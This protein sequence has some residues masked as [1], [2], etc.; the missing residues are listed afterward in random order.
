MRISDWSS[1]VCSSDLGHAALHLGAAGGQRQRKNVA[2]RLARQSAQAVAKGGGQGRRERRVV[3]R[4]QFLG[5]FRRA[6]P[7]HRIGVRRLARKS[8]VTGKRVSE[9]G[10]LGGSRFVQKTK[11]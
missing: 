4:G 10:D 9:R 6:A 1:D 7:D 11:K 3:Q 2:G 5:P 8:V